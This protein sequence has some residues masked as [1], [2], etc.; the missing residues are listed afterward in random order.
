MG[1]HDIG[2]NITKEIE[3]IQGDVTI[4]SGASN[5]TEKG[6]VNVPRYLWKVIINKYMPQHYFF[7]KLNGVFSQNMKVNLMTLMSRR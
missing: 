7:M 4:W 5:Y 6:D 2:I 3:K 1:W